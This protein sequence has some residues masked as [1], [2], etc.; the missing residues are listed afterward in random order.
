MTSETARRRKKVY[1]CPVEFAIDVIGGKWKAVLL[2]RLKE[3]PLAYGELRRLVPDLSD[4][5][6]TERLRELEADGLIERRRGDEG[7]TRYTV[8]SRTAGLRPTLQAL[9]EWGRMTAAE[10]GIEIRE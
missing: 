7:R 2:A 9:Y 3:E 6:L 1:G 5:V 8:T 4:K 10:M